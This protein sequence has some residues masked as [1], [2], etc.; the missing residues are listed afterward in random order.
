MHG[1][2]VTIPCFIWRLVLQCSRRRPIKHEHRRGH[3]FTPEAPWNAHGLEHAPCHPQ[4]SLVPP[5]HHPVL[6]RRVRRGQVVLNSLAGAVL[7]E[8]LRRELAAAVSAQRP[9]LVPDLH[10]RPYLQVSEC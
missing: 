6:L 8:R 1:G 2:L 3:C 7:H 5:L 4:H 10:L 9:Q